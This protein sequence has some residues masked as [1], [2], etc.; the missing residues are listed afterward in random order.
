MPVTNPSRGRLKPH[1]R[2]TRAGRWHVFYR[3]RYGHEFGAAQVSFMTSRST[4]AK[5]AQDWAANRNARIVAGCR[6]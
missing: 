5:A 3:D 4:M 2:K 6:A 1:L